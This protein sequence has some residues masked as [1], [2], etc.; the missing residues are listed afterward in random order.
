MSNYMPI[1]VLIV[2]LSNSRT[3]QG[4]YSTAYHDLQNLT[5][6]SPPMRVTFWGRVLGPWPPFQRRG[7]RKLDLTL[8]QRKLYSSLT[9]SLNNLA[10]CIHNCVVHSIH[11]H[12]EVI[13][14]VVEGQGLPRCH[15]TGV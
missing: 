15:V 6:L 8:L 11:H 14:D 1:K 7:R 3:S 5:F 10:S 12:W 4:K 13:V 9:C 2:L